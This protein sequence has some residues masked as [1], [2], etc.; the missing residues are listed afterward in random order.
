MPYAEYYQKNKEQ[1]KRVARA[2]FKINPYNK[3]KHYTIYNRIVSRCNNKHSWGKRAGITYSVTP[4]EIK[5]LMA[6]DK[7]YTMKRPVLSRINRD[8]GYHKDNLHFIEY[9]EF[10][11]QRRNPKTLREINKRR[12]ELYAMKKKKYSTAGSNGYP[13][14]VVD[15]IKELIE[16]GVYKN[17]T[18]YDQLH[19]EMPTIIDKYDKTL[20]SASITYYKK[21][22]GI[23]RPKNS[24]D[25]KRP[26]QTIP[27]P[28]V[29]IT[30]LLREMIDKFG[31]LQDLYLE[32]SDYD[33][34][35]ETLKIKKQLLKAFFTE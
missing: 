23:L 29:K 31:E 22:L 17:A 25:K 16:S 14:Q 33:S 34:A 32:T 8:L 18:V 13:N 2:Y 7:Y 5:E 3:R 15:R 9:Y 20:L 26:Y 24:G 11:N 1:C 30:I 28:T 10:M 6:R 27:N 12:R 21:K 4:T 19:S 35:K